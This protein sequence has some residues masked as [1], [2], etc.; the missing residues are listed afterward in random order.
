MSIMIRLPLIRGC[1][2]CGKMFPFINV[3]KINPQLVVTDEIDTIT[4]TKQAC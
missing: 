3:S 4:K 2:E 1:M